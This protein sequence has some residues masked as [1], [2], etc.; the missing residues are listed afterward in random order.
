M[1]LL[2]RLLMFLCPIFYSLAR[3]PQKYKTL[4]LLNP[5][6]SQFEL[7]RAAFI[8]KGEISVAYIGYSVA[9]M[10]LLV[11]GGVLLFNKTGDKLI[12]VI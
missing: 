1:Q 12:D 11:S 7:F 9:M 2:V 6:A 5:L 4:V 3:V 8:G 10:L